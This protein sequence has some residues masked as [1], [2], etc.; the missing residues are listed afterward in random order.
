MDQARFELYSPVIT[1]LVRSHLPPDDRVMFEV[2]VLEASQAILE[3]LDRDGERAAL[4]RLVEICMLA[5]TPL[6]RPGDALRR[7]L[8]DFVPPP[9]QPDRAAKRLRAATDDLYPQTSGPTGGSSGAR[10]AREQCAEFERFVLDITDVE[11]LIAVIAAQLA[12]RPQLESEALAADISPAVMRK[13]KE[14][15]ALLPRSSPEEF[16]A[17]VS[18]CSDDMDEVLVLWHAL[19]ASGLR[20]W[21]DERDLVL[22]SIVVTTLC[23]VIGAIE[24]YVFCCGMNL[25]RYQNFEMQQMVQRLIEGAGGH[26]ILPVILTSVA[27]QHDPVPPALA[28]YMRLDLRKTQHAAAVLRLRQAIQV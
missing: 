23:A 21:F 24:K 12:R 4:E 26:R 3:I 10:S 20:V 7:A 22:G 2:E 14:Y 1:Y 11:P 16:D 19:E 28:G 6:D 9:G 17:M 27:A 18:Y 25:G 13:I 5:R 8:S 15:A